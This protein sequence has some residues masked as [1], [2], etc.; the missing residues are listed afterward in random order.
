MTVSPSGYRDRHIGPFLVGHECYS[1]FFAEAHAHDEWQIQVPLRGRIHVTVGQTQH[2]AG[3]ESIILMPPR[4]AHA[5]R[6]LDGELELFNVMAPSSWAS[7]LAA[8]L[9]VPNTPMADARV[10]SEPFV[11]SLASQMATEL[12]RPGLGG[13][14]VLAAGLEQLGIAVVRAYT[15]AATQAPPVDVHL[16]QAI[17]IMLR[18]FGDD[19]T[20]E[21]MARRAGMTPR[22]FTRLF[23]AALGVTPKRFL[24]EIRMRAARELLETTDLP[25]T[26]IAL[27]VGFQQPS[28]FIRT[29]HQAVGM[30]PSAYRRELQPSRSATGEAIPRRMDS[31]I[32]SV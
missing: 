21:A 26:H 24:T 3:P 17:E 20:I 32:G 16:L 31:S 30:S 10:V 12:S 29:F 8:E 28:H 13:D 25:I 27:E 23:K 4:V 9:G 2:L 15:E 6:Y 14:R 1:G 18:D 19:L 5:A 7:G 11:W 22:H